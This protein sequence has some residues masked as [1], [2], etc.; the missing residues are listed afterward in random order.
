MGFSGN[1]RF[2]GGGFGG[3]GGN[4][5]SG[6][7]FGSSGY[8]NSSN[9]FG[10][11]ASKN[12]SSA[13]IPT[14]KI[15][16]KSVVPKSSKMDSMF[17]KKTYH[18]SVN[19]S[20]NSFVKK[21]RAE[22]SADTAYIEKQAEELDAEEVARMEEYLD[23]KSNKFMYMLAYTLVFFFMPYCLNDS[24]HGSFHGKQGSRLFL[25]ALIGNAVVW[26]IGRFVPPLLSVPEYFEPIINAFFGKCLPFMF[27]AFVLF[28]CIFG[29]ISVCM[30]KNNKLPFIGCSKED[31]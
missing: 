4:Y 2:G 24:L 9:G 25:T 27:N 19:E 28:L 17:R 1:N 8:G 23:M 16:G 31:K 7:G 30:G 5:G 3:G 12:S 11:S 15:N 10:S 21:K 29:I 18:S 14:P 13:G 22:D 20:T 6:T 26:A